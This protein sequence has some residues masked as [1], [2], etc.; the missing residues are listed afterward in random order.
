MVDST[1]DVGN[2]HL[3]TY[4]DLFLPPGENTLTITADSGATRTE[5]LLVSETAITYVVITYWGAGSGAR[6][7]YTVSDQPPLFG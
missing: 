7:S 4:Y 6:L 3:Q 2:Q 1:F 5:Q